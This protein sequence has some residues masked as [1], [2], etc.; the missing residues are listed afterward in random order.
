MK[1][2]RPLSLRMRLLLTILMCWVLPILFVLSLAGVLV[3]RNYENSLRQE[4]DTVAGNALEQ[5]Q[6]R[7]EQIFDSSKAVSY[8]GV[9]RN[10]YRIYERNGDS[11]ALY[12]SVNEYISQN[13]TR[14]DKI[15]AIFISFWDL[16]DM[17]TFAAN[18]SNLGYRTLKEYRD[19]VE[20]D[21]L[22]E[23]RDKDTEIFVAEYGGKMYVA[24]NLLSSQLKPYATVVLLCD[25]EQIFQSLDSVRAISNA[26]LWLDERLI[27]DENGV[28]RTMEMTNEAD[29]AAIIYTGGLEGHSLKLEASIQP[30]AF[31]SDIPQIREAAL[32]VILLVLPLMAVAIFLFHRLVGKPVDTLIEAEARLQEGER[33]YQIEQ[34]GGSHE[35]QALFDHFNMMSVELKNQFERSYREQ[36]ALQKAKIK[37]LQSQI[38]PHFLNNTLEIINWEARLGGNERISDMIEALS[39]MLDAALDREGK[40]KVCLRE[41]L[42]YIDAYLYIIKERLGERLEI[43]KEIDE[44][45][46]DTVIPRLILQPLVENAVEHDITAR[47]GGCLTVRA[48]REHDRIILEVEHDGTMSEEDRQS[49][50]FLLEKAGNSEGSSGQVGLLNVMERVRLIYGDDGRLYVDQIGPDTILARLSFPAE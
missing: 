31:W 45:L 40:G 36:Q 34:N 17:K 37:A 44:N 4:L 38:N 28:L 6:L 26:H 47:H 18:R 11:S 25:H 33:G 30:F 21:L 39:V 50:R 16:P 24:R 23:M 1:K 15:A 8:D 42:S 43:R 32:L 48:A 7:L 14:D 35:F 22:E 49:I 12:K 3:S 2:R 10:S 5:V 41:E 29:E 9:V 19:R 20:T 13:F 46:M 27:I